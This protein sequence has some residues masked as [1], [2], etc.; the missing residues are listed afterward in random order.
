MQEAPKR[1]RPESG[2]IRKACQAISGVSEERSS[3]WERASMPVRI[4]VMTASFSLPNIV[5]DTQRDSTE[6]DEIS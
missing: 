3:T 4:I 2:R 1:L 6:N 5:T